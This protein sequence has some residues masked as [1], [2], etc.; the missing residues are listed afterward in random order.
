M[1]EDTIRIVTDDLTSE[2]GVDYTNL[3]NLLASGHWREADQETLAVMLKAA[4]REEEGFLDIE[5]IKK[6]PCTDLHTI[7]Q[8]W[9]KYSKSHFGFSMQKR[10]WESVGGTPDADY[11][12]YLRFGDQVGWVVNNKWLTASRLTFTRRAAKGHLPYLPKADAVFISYEPDTRLWQGVL[13]SGT[14]KV[15]RYLLLGS[16]EQGAE[17]EAAGLFFSRIETCRA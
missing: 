2:R 4:N 10:I 17:G 3:R 7:D 9:V 8:L 14:R 6:F 15:T 11:E 1:D 13:D 12:T 16:V 5:P